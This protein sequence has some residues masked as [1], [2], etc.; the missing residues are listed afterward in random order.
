MKAS[1]SSSHKMTTKGIMVSDEDPYPE[2]AQFKLAIAL[3]NP[4]L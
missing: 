2:P 3:M 4:P 1:G